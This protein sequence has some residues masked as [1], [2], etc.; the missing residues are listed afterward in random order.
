MRTWDHLHLI[1]NFKRITTERKQA[2]KALLYKHYFLHLISILEE[3][4]PTA[5]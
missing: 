3:K 5:I 2:Q 1:S 4:Q